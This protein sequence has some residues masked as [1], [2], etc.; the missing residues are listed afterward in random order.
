IN[1]PWPPFMVAACQCRGGRQHGL[2][3]CAPSDP[4]WPTCAS[5]GG[6][7]GPSADKGGP[8][9]TPSGPTLLA[10]GREQLP[11]PLGDDLDG[12]IGHLDRGLV[13]DGVR[14]TRDVGGPSL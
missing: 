11:G 8:A 3:G 13:V 9:A 12:A 2:S 1:S 5:P 7:V 14:R 10:L 4:G 6:P